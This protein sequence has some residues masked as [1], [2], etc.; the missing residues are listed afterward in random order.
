MPIVL[1]SASPRRQELL[2]NAGI[3]FVVR[4]A[5]ID[6]VQLPG[7]DPAGFAERMARDKARA[8][9]GSVAENVILGADTVVVVGDQVL[10]KPS[11][12]EDAG[13]MLRL[14][15]GRR[16]FVITGVCLIGPDFEDVRSER[17]AVHFTGLTDAEIR[18][19][20]ASGEPMDKAGA[21]AI[22]GRASR[23]IS[24]IEGDYSNVV[25]LP[26]DLVLRMLHEHGVL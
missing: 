23:W 5:N 20:V 10:G 14:L 21:Y 9:R 26:V 16:H 24:K 1:A 11:D 12:P 7:E 25:G 19:Y 18:D 17:T 3:D 2:Q 8:V 4:P 6:E 15:S 13:R 22:Q